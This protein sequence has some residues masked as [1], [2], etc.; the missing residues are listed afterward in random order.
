APAKKAAPA[1]KP[2]AKA[3][4]ANKAAPAKKAVAPAKKAVAPAKKPVVKKSVAP[5]KAPVKA[6]VKK[7]VAPAKAPAKKPVASAKKATA[8]AKSA[9]KKAPVPA[10]AVAKKAVAPAK[11]AAK[12]PETSVAPVVASRGGRI[13]SP[14]VE[15][16]A[17]V[18]SEK[19][20]KDSDAPQKA[21]KSAGGKDAKSQ[22]ASSKPSSGGAPTKRGA[23]R[24]STVR[25]PVKPVV[26]QEYS[27]DMS[28]SRSHVWVYVESNRAE[29]H[30]AKVGITDYLVEEL[31]N[32]ENIDLPLEDD[33]LEI[34][35]PVIL[36]HT[37]LRKKQVRCP[38]TGRVLEVN[39][40][41]LDDPTLLF[42]D[43]RANWLFR[44]EFDEP[45]EL[46]LLMSGLQYARY[47]DEL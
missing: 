39:Q 31:A 21:P 29:K 18:V 38:L 43:Y 22:T 7:P 35:V 25:Q 24:P 40:E 19:L 11:A 27:D 36:L 30:Y 13:P 44:M 46:D 6:A 26:E 5:A 45:D 33:E 9:P 2:E 17:K 15:K 20:A 47:L 28:Y 3:A 10:K 16:T 12:K 14:P 34:D 23:G 32:I 37:G 42:K 41:V 4:P 1:Q 8:P